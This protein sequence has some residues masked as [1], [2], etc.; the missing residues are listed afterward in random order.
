MKI[1]ILLI[2]LILVAI[3]GCIVNGLNVNNNLNL[4]EA[5]ITK[6]DI[7]ITVTEYKFVDYFE[8]P[9]IN[10]QVQQYYP[11]EG[12][13]FLL[14]YMKVTNIGSVE[15]PSDTIL[16]TVDQEDT[17]TILY[18]GTKIVSN[19]FKMVERNVYQIFS[20]Y[21]DDYSPQFAGY[22]SEYP[23]VTKEGWIMFIVPA[24]IDLSKTELEI[25]GLK[26]EFN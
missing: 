24:N 6:D 16:L 1:H 9:I 14:I 4:G 15:A 13:K 5:G 2:V 25:H 3:S 19:E 20:H 7:E 11:P 21:G 17:P 23:N 22:G 12:A 10:N 8:Y 18:A 26:W